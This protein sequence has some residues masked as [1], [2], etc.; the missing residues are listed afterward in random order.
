MFYG[1][2]LI[3]RI[4]I[5]NVYMTFGG[6]SWGW[7]AGPVVYTSYDYGA[8]IS[9]DRGL[10][11]KALSLKQQGMFVQA[12]EQALAKMD[13]GPEITTSSPKAKVYHNVNPDLGTHVLFAVHSPSDLTTDDSFTFDLATA[14]GKYQVPLR[15]NGQDAKM[16]L[17]NYQLERQHLVYSTS[18]IQTHFANG[19]RDIAL[20]HGRDGEAGETVLRFK[21]EPK[22][23]VLAGQVAARFDAA[24]GDLKLTY[25]HDGL[26]RVR[27]TG[28]GRAPLLLL[29]ADNRHSLQFWRQ[30][31]PAGQV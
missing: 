5:H 30:N 11:A 12:A 22:V 28:G 2:N 3:N 8:P 9:E 25:T 15:L 17:A 23:E 6:T 20:L 21:G 24:T 1:T 14:D 7:L 10:R 31:T 27:I 13:K 29:L 4:T 18:E 26:A 19:E 16:L